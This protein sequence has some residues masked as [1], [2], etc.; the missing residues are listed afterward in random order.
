MVM[1][2]GMKGHRVLEK[3]QDI[4]DTVKGMGWAGH[5]VTEV[6]SQIIMLEFY[7]IVQ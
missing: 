3:C 4:V 6:W 5:R 1:H 2:R 7:S